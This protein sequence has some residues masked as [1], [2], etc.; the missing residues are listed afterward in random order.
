MSSAREKARKLAAELG[1]SSTVASHPILVKTM[2]CL[3]RAKPIGQTGLS[4]V[5]GAGVIHIDA[6]PASFDRIE[7]APTRILAVAGAISAELVRSDGG[8]AFQCDGETVEFRIYE[9]IAR[10][11]HVE[12]DAERAS[13][14]AWLRRNERR[15]NSWNNALPF[16]PRP[17][18]PELPARQSRLFRL[19]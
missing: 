7:L 11:K 9:A 10:E 16:V 19:Q 13:Q 6:A 8:A 12:T 4:L 1:V 2:A 18:V 14:D 3:R 5:K 15:R 17:S